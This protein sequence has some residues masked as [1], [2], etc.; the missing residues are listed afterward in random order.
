MVWHPILKV[1]HA[2]SVELLAKASMQA[3]ALQFYAPAVKSAVH[4]PSFPINPVHP[5]VYAYEEHANK[6]LTQPFPV[7]THP[8]RNVL[9]A[10]F[11]AVVAG[12]SVHA[13]GLQVVAPVPV[14]AVQAPSL[15][16]IPV[17]PTAIV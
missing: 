17:H 9:Q 7:V 14:L 4:L 13:N 11:V 16:I 5:N 10:V 6:V 8:E 1:L 3:I 2:A 15:P 12:A